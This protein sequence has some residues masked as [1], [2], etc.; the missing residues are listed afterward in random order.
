MTAPDVRV[1]KLAFGFELQGVLTA[2]RNLGAISGRLPYIQERAISTLRRRIPVEARR[3]IQKEYAIKAARV[4]KD[5]RVSN[6]AGG[7]RI[8]GYWRGI[9]LTNYGARDLRKS[10]G[11]VSYMIFRGVRSVRPR[12]FIAPLLKGKKGRTGNVHVAHREGS[13]R[14]MRAGRYLGQM[15]QPIVTDYGPTV[16]QMLAKGR[17]PQRLADYAR[18]VLGRE[19]ARLTAVELKKFGITTPGASA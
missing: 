11:G 17:R 5:L 6:Y 7:I 2:S 13:K 9:G 14:K 4:N 1:S 18:G 19:M 12:S 15:R 10:G 3:D 8:T 16:A